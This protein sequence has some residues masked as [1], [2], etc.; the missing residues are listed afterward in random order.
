MSKDERRAKAA[1]VMREFHAGKLHHGGTG[2]IVRN[3]KVAKAIAMS[4][5]G[6]SR[7]RK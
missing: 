2:K 5:A 6:L 4:E 3:V 1:K 7:K